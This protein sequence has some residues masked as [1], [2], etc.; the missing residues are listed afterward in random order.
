MKT[1]E[2]KI[3]KLEQLNEAGMNYVWRLKTP[4]LT[5]GF[6][7]NYGRRMSNIIYDLK[8]NHFNEYKSK[9]L[10]M[11]RNLTFWQPRRV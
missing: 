10:I 3:K 4:R 11:L 2:D 7:S 5:E 8:Q 9:T 6:W 1:F